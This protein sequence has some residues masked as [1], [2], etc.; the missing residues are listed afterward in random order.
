MNS[1]GFKLFNILN[2]K[3]KKKLNKNMKY[4]FQKSTSLNHID[5]MLRTYGLELCKGWKK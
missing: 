3:Q 4:I 2:W 5:F 1:R